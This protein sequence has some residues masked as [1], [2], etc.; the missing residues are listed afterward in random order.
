MAQN[1][2][3]IAV[4]VSPHG[5]GHAAR[6]TAVMAALQA[7]APDPG[8]EVFTTVPRWFFA[9]SLGETAFGYH[10]C[11]TDLGLVQRTPFMEDIAGTIRALDDLLPFRPAVVD[12][13][14]ARIR[15]LG[16]RM[17]LCDIAPLGIAVARRA[18][19]PAVLVEN[20]LWDWIYQGYGDAALDRHGAYLAALFA[21]A[22]YHVQATPACLPRPADLHAAPVSRAPRTVPAQMRQA[23][24]VE[25]GQK[26][27]LLTLGG[28]RGG[29]PSLKALAA[30][31]D[32]CFVIPGASP[33]PDFRGN[34]RLLPHRS[35]FFHPDLMA[36]A[37]AV[38]G[39]LG[40]S[41]VAELYYAGAPFAYVW[42]ER[43]RES[44]P[45]G[46]FVSAEM[47]GFGIAPD[48]FES[49]AWLERLDELLSLPPRPR[50]EENGATQ[51]ARFML[52][53][54]PA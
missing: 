32:V 34:L 14:A 1:T 40:Y 18:G 47:A 9:D 25:A 36:A 19:L 20:F 12:A 39:K 21:Q 45:L 53:H 7:L 23:L 22:D 43:F 49:G 3:R 35:S 50:Q 52:A 11:L 15:Q 44:A 41:T 5:F 10:E 28:V 54:W 29:F 17:V 33:A 27:L 30:R 46:A 6:A 16:C 26:M 4:F 48:A 38:A 2:R 42:R 31:D 51:I 37:D 13:L 8:F 24:A